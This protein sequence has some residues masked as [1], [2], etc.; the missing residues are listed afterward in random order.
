MLRDDLATHWT[1]ND[2]TVRGARVHY[3]RTGS[4]AAPNKPA[5]VLAHGFS[6]NG[7]CWQPMAE[8]LE[9]SYDVIMP[10]ARGHGLS[11]RV[12]H[13]ETLDPPADLAEF[14][15]AMGLERPIVGGH[16]MGASTAFQLGARYPDLVRALILEDP[17]WFVPQ[18]GATGHGGIR[19]K[20]PLGQ[21]IMS[22]QD[23]TLEQVMD[24]CRIDHPT[25]PEIVVRR[26]CEGKKQL[27]P[28]FLSTEN[29]SIT[30][31]WRALVPSI[32]C[33]TLI[34]TADPDKGGIVTPEVAQGVCAANPRLRVAHIPGVGHHVRFG[35][36][37]TYMRAVWDL[38]KEIG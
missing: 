4:G 16:S 24:Q 37:A 2:I 14:I 8:E 30:G 38:L 35:D 19:A 29:S 10:D 7:L 1:P 31:E 34:L 28:T 18:P 17:P 22:L 13:G 27:D 12:Q 9:S 32:S 33:P 26:W 11:Q 5:M 20:S 25:W 3:Y 15:R 23:L 36:Q 21:W 6:D